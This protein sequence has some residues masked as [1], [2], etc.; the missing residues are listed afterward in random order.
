MEEVS[1]KQKDKFVKDMTKGE[2]ILL[3]L[4][5]AI[6]LLIGN[7][8]QQAYNLTDSIIV[9]RYVGKV[10]LGG[11]GSTASITTLI[12]SLTNGLSIGIGIIVAHYYGAKE[13]RKVKNTIGNAY[14]IVSLTASL[15]G[16]ISLIFGGYFLNLL[17]TPQDTFPYA[18]IYLRTIS[19]GFISISF[20]NIL[21]SI[22]RA[23]G[24]SKTPLLFLILSCI[25]NIFLDLIFVIYFNLGVMGVG[26]ATSASQFISA[27]LCFIYAIKS[28]SYFRLDKSDFNYSQEIFLKVIKVGIPIALQN[29]FI[30]ISLIALQRVVNEFGS[31]LVTAYTIVLRI[32]LL[33]QYPFMSLG[34]A[35][36][37]YTGQNL[38]AGKEE[39]VKLG[40]IR[41]ILCSSGFSL[42]I[43]IIFQ[44]FSPII[45][46]IFGNDPSVIK[47]AVKGLKITCSF[48][49]FL[50]FIY[51]TR[52]LLNG[53]GDTKFSMINGAIEC[54]GRVCLA[55]PLT[56]IPIIGLN[57]VW[58]TTGITWLLNGL[59]GIIR[60]KQG[61]W[62]TIALV[63]KSNKIMIV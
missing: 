31:D 35:L 40:F 4:E 3:L 20:F 14:Y 32:E 45:V 12:N 52:N 28:N 6:P 38:G 18:V 47:Y 7:L 56:M 46:N 42:F 51:V 61:K 22:L 5:F 17:H 19:I 11:V 37:N 57:G 21:S 62:K 1:L 26:I 44:N 34:I 48:Y 39:R 33:V 41:A 54:I 29:S 30:A 27:F 8:F 10:A 49:I 16:C 43:F 53:A 24:D 13:D 25:F 23:L 60:Y 50:G 55:K 36:A 15:M 63:N 59:F 9:G 2:P 58:L